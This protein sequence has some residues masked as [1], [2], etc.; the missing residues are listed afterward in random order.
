RRRQ[1]RTMHFGKIHAALL[2]QRTLLDDARATAATT[3][4]LPSIFDEPLASVGARQFRTQ[5]I[6]Q[7]GEP[8]ARRSGV[9]AGRRHGATG[10]GACVRSCCR[11][12]PFNPP[13]S[14]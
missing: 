7:T 1:R 14:A 9:V 11:S 4:P 5:P 12:I 10:G 2:E 13:C 3:G 8:V 6:L